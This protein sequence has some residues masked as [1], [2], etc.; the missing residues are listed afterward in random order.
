V[1]GQ[2]DADR[3]VERAVGDLAVADL[4]ADRVDEDLRIDRLQ[5]P[6]GPIG[7]LGND[8]VGDPGDG[9]RRDRRVVEFGEMRR[10]LP[11]G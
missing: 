4:H 9:V 7:H 11:G 10:D 6:R 8:L 3:G 1:P 2:I 5:R